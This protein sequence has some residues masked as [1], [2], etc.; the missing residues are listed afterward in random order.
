MS[1]PA[2]ERQGGRRGNFAS[3]DTHPC[4]ARE[5][6]DRVGAPG[7]DP[8][9]AAEGSLLGELAGARSEMH[10]SPTAYHTNLRTAI[11]FL[12]FGVLLLLG[13]LYIVWLA[14][15]VSHSLF[16]SL[17]LSGIMSLTD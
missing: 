11:A 9:L 16:S 13:K 14:W 2:G 1:L 10:P 8:L 7:R 15:L 6:H 4:R 12:D 5:R 3:G 17:I